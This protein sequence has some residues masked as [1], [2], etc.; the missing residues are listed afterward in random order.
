MCVYT[1]HRSM[2]FNQL[3][4]RLR[5]PCGCWLLVGPQATRLL[6][7][8]EGLSSSQLRFA[9]EFCGTKRCCRAG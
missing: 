3:S 8:L 5:A 7:E 1:V 9:V 4:P 2:I 6:V